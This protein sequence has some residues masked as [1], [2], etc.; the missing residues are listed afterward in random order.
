MS[1]RETDLLIS[2]ADEKNKGFLDFKDFFKI[3][4]PNMQNLNKLG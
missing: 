4:K 1:K 2:Y 3:L